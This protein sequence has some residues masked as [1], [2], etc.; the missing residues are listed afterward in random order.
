MIEIKIPQEIVDQTAK[1]YAEVLPLLDEEKRRKW[2]ETPNTVWGF[3][4]ERTLKT[5]WGVPYKPLSPKGDGGIDLYIGNMK[6]DIKARKEYY[7]RK[8]TIQDYGDDY[9]YN[10]D[11][12][13]LATYDIAKRTIYLIGFITRSQIK[14]SGSPYYF[15]GQAIPEYGNG[16]AHHNEY[17]IS[18]EII[19]KTQL[20][21]EGA[22]INLNN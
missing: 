21:Y 17:I 13:I 3:I 11:M 12:Y 15:L 7:P 4:V 10:P 1:E 8:W 14:D 16:R 9:V 22:Y 6:V 18:D 19:P 2:E 20:I 5:R